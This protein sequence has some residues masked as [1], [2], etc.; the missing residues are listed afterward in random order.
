MANLNGS[1]LF[2]NHDRI[3]CSY[4]FCDLKSPAF[5]N[6]NKNTPTGELKCGH[7]SCSYVC[8]FCVFKKIF[9][10]FHKDDATSKDIPVSIKITDNMPIEKNH[11][12]NSMLINNERG[13]PS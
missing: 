8:T 6:K 4:D 10:I 5:T 1:S 11:A 12:N 7:A 13:L 9:E 2:E 3:N